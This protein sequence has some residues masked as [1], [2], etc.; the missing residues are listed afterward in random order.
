MSFN[1]LNA[2]I[3]NVA[4]KNHFFIKKNSKTDGVIGERSECGLYILYE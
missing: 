1:L 3:I 4:R 2:R